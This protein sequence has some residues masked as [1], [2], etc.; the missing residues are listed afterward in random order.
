MNGRSE[1]FALI[2]T[3]R[4]PYTFLKTNSAFFPF[5]A[6]CYATVASV[7]KRRHRNAFKETV[8]C[9]KTLAQC[10]GKHS[11]VITFSSW[12]R[13]WQQLDNLIAVSIDL[14]LELLLSEWPKFLSFV[15]EKPGQSYLKEDKHSWLVTHCPTAFSYPHFTFDVSPRRK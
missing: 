15:I 14:S 13:L 7:V 1:L 10:L 8:K 4:F 11:K 9:R 6:R 5:D 2:T 3:S 12:L